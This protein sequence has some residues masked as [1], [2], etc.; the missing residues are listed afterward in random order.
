MGGRLA[1][2]IALEFPDLV[3]RLVMV[4]AGCGIADRAERAHRN[5]SDSRWIELIRHHGSSVFLEQWL[6]QQIFSRLDISGFDNRIEDERRLMDQLRVL[7]QGV[8]PSYWERLHE[9]EMPVT[10]IVGALDTTYRQ[11][12]RDMVDRIGPN[13]RVRVIADAGHP[14]IAEAP[15]RLATLLRQ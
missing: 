14:L 4:S 11:L 10:L 15:K 7:G 12:A 9:L 5:T 3:E 6:G 2:G 13:A 8:M 1:L